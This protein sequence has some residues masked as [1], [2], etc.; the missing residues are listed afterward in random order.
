MG[1]HD[2][3]MTSNSHYNK[4]QLINKDILLFQK[5]LQEPKEPQYKDK[6]ITGQLVG[7]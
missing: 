4:D 2:G 3:L 6:I 5:G 1:V 7:S